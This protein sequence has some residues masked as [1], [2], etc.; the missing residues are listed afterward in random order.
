LNQ[1]SKGVHLKRPTKKHP[2]SVDDRDH[3][4][5]RRIRLARLDRQLSQSEL[6]AALGISFQ[7]VQKYEK[8]TNRIT[9]GRLEQI[10]I[11]LKI[12]PHELMGWG[13]TAIADDGN[14]DLEAYKLA[15]AFSTLRDE[16]KSPVRQLINSLMRDS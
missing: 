5:G 4:Y 12:T 11:A 15:K 14:L 6:G 16:W 3:E 10:A 13:K 2:R 9:V 1:F 8:G 7:Q